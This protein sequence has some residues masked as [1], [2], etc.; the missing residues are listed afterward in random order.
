MNSVN[1]VRTKITEWKILSPILSKTGCLGFLLILVHAAYNRGRCA[2]GSKVVLPTLTQ[3]AVLSTR[4]RQQTPK[5]APKAAWNCCISA[6]IFHM[7]CYVKEILGR[8]HHS[9]SWVTTSLMKQ[10]E[11][12]TVYPQ[13][14]NHWYWTLPSGKHTPWAVQVQL[15]DHYRQT[16]VR[17]WPPNSPYSISIQD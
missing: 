9:E 17:T 6:P 10:Q 5:I 1:S 16:E 14:Q 11:L 2:S 4:W 3:M 13:H 7:N 15:E 8:H 12:R